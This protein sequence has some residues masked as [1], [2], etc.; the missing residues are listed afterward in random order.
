MIIMSMFINIAISSNDQDF[1]SSS[2]CIGNS[3][4]GNNVYRNYHMSVSSLLSNFTLEPVPP[5]PRFYSTYTGPPRDRAYGS[6]ICWGDISSQ[7]CKKCV[8]HVTES[9]S[10]QDFY[11]ECYAIGYYLESG[12]CLVQYSNKSVNTY[13]NGFVFS[14]G[15]IGGKVADYLPYNKTLSK[16][17]EGLIKEATIGNWT[18][19][20]LATRVVP[21]T[22]TRDEIHILVQC[23]P[24]ISSK[25]CSRCLRELY[26]YVPSHCNG[27]QGGVVVHANCVLKFSNQTF[28]GG[29]HGSLTPSYLHCF[30][31]MLFVLCTL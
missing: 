2:M 17:I 22:G 14:M 7:L 21:V 1:G 28:I 27:T 19:T 13:I 30:L 25:N 29:V 11:Q 15:N 18:R 26:D 5:V 23:I 3:T 20:N 16:T 12:L 9:L 6:Y 4:N 24:V 10:N 8:S 31:V